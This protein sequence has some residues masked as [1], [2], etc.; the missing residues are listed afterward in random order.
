MHFSK[1]LQY[2]GTNPRASSLH[3]TCRVY[4]FTLLPHREGT[5]PHGCNRS[6]REK[7]IK[8]PSYPA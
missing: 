3:C 6:L 7:P 1:A 8:F 4:T 2:L 5:K